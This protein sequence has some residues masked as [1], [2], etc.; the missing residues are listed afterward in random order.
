MKSAHTNLGEKIHAI[1][2]GFHLSGA[3]NEVA[4]DATVEGFKEFEPDVI[5]PGHCTG[6]RA[7]QALVTQFG[8]RVVPMAVGMGLDM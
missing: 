1:V 8:A 5:V 2:G 4:I 3:A 6:W 7:V